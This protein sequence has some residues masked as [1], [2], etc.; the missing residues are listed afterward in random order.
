[1]RRRVQSRIIRYALTEVFIMVEKYCICQARSSSLLG[2]FS[3]SQLRMQMGTSMQLI[4][5]DTFEKNEELY[6]YKCWFFHRVDLHEGLRILAMD[7]SGPGKP[8]TITLDSEVTEVD[9]EKGLL[10]L[11]NGKKVEKD[12]IVVADGAHVSTLSPQDSGAVP[13]GC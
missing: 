11:A 7:S 1:M 3:V 9:C 4:F 6:G 5:Q 2:G 10:T 8:I 13:A 12:L